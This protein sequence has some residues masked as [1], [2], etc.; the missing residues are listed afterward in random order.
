LLAVASV[1]AAFSLLFTGFV[2]GID[3]NVFHLPIVA[4]LYDEPQ[5]QHDT[6]IQSLR[7][8]SSGIWL[9][10]GGTA[11]WIDPYAL[12]LGL[13]FVSRLLAFVGFLLCATLLGVR[14]MRPACVFA[15]LICF[16]SLLQ[17]EA[18]AGDGGLFLNYF[19]HSEMANGTTLIAIYYVLRARP[20][21]AVVWVGI[22]FFI[23]I[24]MA[25]WLLVPFAALA[26]VDLAAGRLQPRPLL[27]ELL[28]AGAVFCLL[29]APVLV[30]LVSNPEFAVPPKFDYTAFTIF[31]YPYHFMPNFT[32]FREYVELAVVLV[33]GSMSLLEL[34]GAADRLRVVFAGM[35]LTYIAGAL[36]LLLVTTQLLLNLSL[37]RSGVLLYLV[38][39]LTSAAVATTWLGSQQRMVAR[40]FA[41]ALIIALCTVKLLLPAA[42]VCIGLKWVWD[43]RGRDFALPRL[44][45]AVFV[46]LALTV[47]PW[48]Y[49]RNHKEDSREAS[50]S[51]ELARVGDWAREH[52]AADAVFLLPTEWQR[53]GFHPPVAPYVVIERNI[54]EAEGSFVYHSHRRVRG[55]FKQGAAMLWS[56]SYYS[57]WQP[58]IAATLRLRT[59]AQKLGY[60]RRQHIDYILA[61]CLEAE[62]SNPAIVMHTEHVCV[63]AVQ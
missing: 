60:A 31:H 56:P 55:S 34:R 29:A 22:T 24:F 51:S 3:N 6:F 11:R 37:L 4:S 47:W 13:A 17:G 59:L 27:R 5:F 32:P 43:V 36:L 30:N 10:L 33:L 45:W 53:K 35:A 38:A 49:A 50:Y 46:L 2:F 54:V 15:V 42:L 57:E 28:R 8:F 25:A 58:E 18:A 52:T 41:P 1:G 62:G 23:N 12:F 61:S 26:A 7:Y 9:I 44:D 16:A 14:G 48:A 40:V 19:T 39:G 20:A 63:F 21:A